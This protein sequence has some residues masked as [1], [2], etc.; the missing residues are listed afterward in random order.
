M[1]VGTGQPRSAVAGEAEASRI[2]LVEDNPHVAETLA[3]LL[4]LEGFRVAVVEEAEAGL[5]CARTEPPHLVLCD[6]TLPGTLEGYGFARAC[7][8]D[9]DQR[10]LRLVAVSGH[11][12]AEDRRRAIEAGFDDLIAKPIELASIH[13]AFRRIRDTA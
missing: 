7:R 2:L 6:L 5:A 8:A 9:P 10:E 12:R 11:C 1:G 3:E 4:E 13:A